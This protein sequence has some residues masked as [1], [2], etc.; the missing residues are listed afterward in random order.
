MKEI[1]LRAINRG[2]KIVLKICEFGKF[3]LTLQVE[4]PVLA[5]LR[6]DGEG[7]GTLNALYLN[8]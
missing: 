6:L 8:S 7:S 4:T 3:T 5:F 1:G 2:K